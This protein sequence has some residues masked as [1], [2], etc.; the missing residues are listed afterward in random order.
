MSA[1]E[2]RGCGV[3]GEQWTNC[4]RSPRL[5]VYTPLY[6]SISTAPTE[7][8]LDATGANPK[9]SQAASQGDC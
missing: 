6:E 4:D 5:T 3:S 2:W 9:S 8:D 7:G 1:D